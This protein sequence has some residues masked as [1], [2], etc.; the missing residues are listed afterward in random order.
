M[1]LSEADIK[2]LKEI[3]DDR[4]EEMSD[5]EDD[6]E[7]KKESI[8]ID[9]VIG[10]LKLISSSLT[11]IKTGSMATAELARKIEDISKILGRM[12]AREEAESKKE[13]KEGKE[14]KKD[15]MHGMH[16]EQLMSIKDALSKMTSVDYTD[17]LMSIAKSVS[18]EG[19]KWEFDVRYTQSGHIEKVIAIKK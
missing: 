7:D 2:K 6:S 15:K 4:I 14:G 5:E 17:P 8:Q 10:Q 19:E 1:I 12:D 13:E 16:M 11:A 18:R 9:Q 3:V